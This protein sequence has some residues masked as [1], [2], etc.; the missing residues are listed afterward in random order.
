MSLKTR[1]AWWTRQETTTLKDP[2]TNP[3]LLGVVSTWHKKIPADLS[4]SL[5]SS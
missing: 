2:A 4:V 5:D 1:A 3:P